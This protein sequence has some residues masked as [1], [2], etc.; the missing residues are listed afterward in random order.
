MKWFDSLKTATRVFLTL[1]T[2]WMVMGLAY[3]DYELKLFG[4]I[5]LLSGV[6]SLVTAR[7]A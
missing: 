4:V 2:I 7:R 5:F 6:V 3:D 1:G